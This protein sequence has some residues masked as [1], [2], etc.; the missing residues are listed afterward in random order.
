[1][2]YTVALRSSNHGHISC[3]W[4]GVMFGQWL[5]KCFSRPLNK[6]SR[7]MFRDLWN[8]LH[9]LMFSS[10]ADFPVWVGR[11]DKPL[12]LPDI[13][14]Y[15]NNHTVSSASTV[16]WNQCLSVINVC[17]NNNYNFLIVLATHI[18]YKN[19]GM[20]RHW[21]DHSQ[22]IH[23]HHIFWSNIYTVVIATSLAAAFY[24]ILYNCAGFP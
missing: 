13:H 17:G 18:L 3:K 8:V 11:I 24:W 5:F 12:W 4:Y 1:M 14:G 19:N 16:G 21:S 23:L 9:L 6:D 7:Y 22:Y 10:S 15:T 20:Y 2:K